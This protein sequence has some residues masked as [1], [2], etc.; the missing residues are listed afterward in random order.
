[1]SGA[2]PELNPD[3]VYDL[4]EGIFKPQFVRLAL[5]LDVFTP[6]AD[7]AASAE[8]VARSCRCDAIG[9]KHLLD[10][11][12][13]L[14]VLECHQDFYALTPTASAFL[15][16]GRKAYAGDMIL[17]Y[18]DKS[19]FDSIRVSLRSGNPAS[20]GENF[21]QDAWLESYREWRILKCLEMWQAAGILPGRQEGL[22]ILDI[23]CGCAIK[24]LALAQASPDVRVTCLDSAEVLVVARDLAER[25]GVQ[26]QVEFMPANLL[27]ADLGEN[28]F[29]AALAGQ[30]THYLTDEQNANLFQRIYAALSQGGVFVIDCPM[31][32]D[33]PSETTSFLTLVLWANS[34]GAAHSFEVYRDGLRDSGFRQVKQLSERWL[35]VFK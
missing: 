24:S 10:Y 2:A 16:K 13:A 12:C 6:L 31:A 25:M 29:D 32:A 33:E 7:G 9:I 14:M 22:R 20:M 35:A 3:L 5:Q 18:T 11:L 23:A 26:S 30:I 19:L 17:H 8:Q 15:V 28:Q 4:Y 34:G 27:D 1:M 21:V